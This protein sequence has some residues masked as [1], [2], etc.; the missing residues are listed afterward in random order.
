MTSSVSRALANLVTDPPPTPHPGAT[1]CPLYVIITLITFDKKSAES[2]NKNHSVG[3]Q[4]T[5]SFIVPDN[6]TFLCPFYWPLS[7]V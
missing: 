2:G 6:R 3:F 5:A 4:T 1:T 7:C